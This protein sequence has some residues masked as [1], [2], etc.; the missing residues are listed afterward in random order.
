[1]GIPRRLLPPTA[2]LLAFEAAARTGNFTQAAQELNYTQSAISRQIRALE[3]RLGTELFIR[4]R[5]R[6]L[7]TRA[8]MS[9]ARSIAGA[10]RSIAEASLSI[11]ANPR[12]MSLRLAMLPTFGSRWLIPK[13]HMFLAQ[14]PDVSLNFSARPVPFDFDSE[15]FDCAIHFGALNWAGSESVMLMGETVVPVA[16][17]RLMDRHQFNQPEDL[18]Q[19][20]LLVLSSR[21]GSWVR[22]FEHNGVCYS[23]E[24]GLLF[25]QFDAL[26]AAA[27]A[28]LGIALVPRFLFEDEIN[29]GVLIPVID[30]DAPS[31]HSYHLVWP[32]DRRDN[33]TMHLFRDWIQQQTRDFAEQCPSFSVLKKAQAINI[34]GPEPLPIA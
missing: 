27:K 4:D 12:S 13:I 28:G 9:Y 26:V 2:M 24:E 5:Q 11:Q 30:Q 3:E 21:V 20:P 7:L 23:Q 17:R 19:A 16:G 8:G 31:E 34:S 10:L 32:Q 25:D 18:L 33:P 14:H 15:P 22:W 6:V 29:S 1:M